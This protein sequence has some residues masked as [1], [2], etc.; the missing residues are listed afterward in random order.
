MKTKVIM[1]AAA[2]TAALVLTGCA[3]TKLV[4]DKPGYTVIMI[5][6]RPYFQYK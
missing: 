4:A 5:D 1:L 3:G 2:L 6:K